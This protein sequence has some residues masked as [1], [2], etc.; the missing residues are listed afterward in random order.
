[1]ITHSRAGTRRRLPALPAFDDL[2]E[3]DGWGQGGTG[4]GHTALPCD[5]SGR[6]WEQGC[7]P[8]VCSGGGGVG[9]GQGSRG[10]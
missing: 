4:S 2:T 7:S 8:G 6:L 3:R 10:K 1:M 9:E 5:D